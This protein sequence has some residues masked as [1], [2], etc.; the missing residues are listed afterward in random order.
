MGKRWVSTVK[1]PYKGAKADGWRGFGKGLGKGF[2][3]LL[4]R[5]RGIV[6][7]GTQY[8]ARALYNNIKEHFGTGTLSFILA[9]HFAQGFEEAHVSIEEERLDVLRRWHELAPDLK[10]EQSRSRTVS[11][12]SLLGSRSSSTARSASTTSAPGQRA[13]ITDAEREHIRQKQIE[14]EKEIEVA[15]AKQGIHDTVGQ[16]YNAVPERGRVWRKTDSRAGSAQ[17][18]LVELDTTSARRDGSA[19]PPFAELE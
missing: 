10:Q 16:R 17:P 15:N 5:Q 1:E 7:N 12:S 14:R 3:N 2:G 9:A 18:A 8:G 19:Q 11:S 4:F 6:I 13:R